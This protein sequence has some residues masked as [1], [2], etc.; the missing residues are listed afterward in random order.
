M[1]QMTRLVAGAR[2]EAPFDGTVFRFKDDSA[3]LETRAGGE[4]WMTVTSGRYGTKSY[5]VTRVIGGHHREDFVG[6]DGFEELVL[7]VSFLLKSRTFR[8]KGYSV[9]VHERDGLRAGPGWNRTCILCPNT[10]PSLL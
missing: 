8:Y 1:H 3:S 4:R 7:P 5:K 9:M 10:A 2:I 6:T